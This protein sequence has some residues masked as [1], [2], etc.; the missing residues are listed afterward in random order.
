MS[1]R[2]KL[3]TIP[4]HD[5]AEIREPEKI[6][7]D[8]A[9]IILNYI[10]SNLYRLG[11]GRLYTIERRRDDEY[12]IYDNRQRPRHGWARYTDGRLSGFI[13]SSQPHFHLYY[14]NVNQNICIHFKD[15]VRRNNYQYDLHSNQHDLNDVVDIDDF[16]N[17]LKTTSIDG[18]LKIRNAVLGKGST[19]G[20][21]LGQVGYPVFFT[22]QFIN[23]AG[24]VSISQASSSSSSAPAS[25]LSSVGA[26]PISLASLSSSAPA[27]RLS[28]YGPTPRNRL[29]NQYSP[30]S[31][32]ASAPRRIIMSST[33]SSSVPAP[34]PAPGPRRSVSIVSNTCTCGLNGCTTCSRCTVCNKIGCTRCSSSS[35][36]MRK[37]KKRGMKKSKKSKKRGM[38]KSVK[39]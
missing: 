20:L 11:N 17:R 36:G 9:I 1:K 22:Q 18:S 31:R 37:S 24:A 15:H 21:G 14:D 27:S 38:R 8:N 10:I 29:I 6:D 39:C 34:V 23:S 30:Y 32:P 33:L 25:I 26:V 7:L 12:F 3:I 5:R 19:D 13:D 4:I 35:Y 2:G 28:S 16:I